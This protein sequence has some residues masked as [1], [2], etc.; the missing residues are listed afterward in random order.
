M[1][2]DRGQVTHGGL[3]PFRAQPE[4]G[5]FLELGPVDDEFDVTQALVEFTKALFAPHD[6]VHDLVNGRVGHEGL[7]PFDLL[8]FSGVRI[9]RTRCKRVR[10]RERGHA[11]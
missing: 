8:R 10:Q 4:A 6:V 5:S 9:R 11:C 2:P 1:T 3:H 7:D